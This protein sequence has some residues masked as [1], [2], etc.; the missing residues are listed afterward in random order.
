LQA[1]DGSDLSA[2]QA[3]IELAEVPFVSMR[4]LFVKELGR[5]V[6]SFTHL[7]EQCRLN[8]RIRAGEGIRLTLESRRPTAQING[9]TVRFSAREHL[10]LLFIASRAKDRSP[11]FPYYGACIDDL[12]EFRIDLIQNAPEDDFGDWR[13]QDSLSEV[14]E[15]K[16]LTR[17]VSDLRRKIQKLGGEA[18]VLAGCLPEKGRFSLDM[19]PSLIE[20]R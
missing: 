10:I 1:R 9:Q 11:A 3:E 16:D 17:L 18:S 13:H 8:V 4:N 6:G 20:I 15:E 2:A 14:F 12:N 5:Q 19:E 7:V